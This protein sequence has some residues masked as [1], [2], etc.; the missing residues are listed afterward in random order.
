[1]IRGDR[2]VMK[3]FALF[4][5]GVCPALLL[6]GCAASLSN[7]EDFMDGGTAPRS[8]EMILAESCGGIAG[9]HDSTP[10]AAAGLDLVSPDVESRVVGVNAIGM[11]C[12]SD[13]L[14]V[15][16]N[17]DGSYLLDKVI[18]SLGICGLAMP[19]GS[20]PPLSA[21]EVETL[22]QW[23]IDLG[24]ESDGGTPDGG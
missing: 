19:T 7:P 2:R 8:A 14:V 15:A 21:D 1:M 18:P 5:F 3:R 9:C 16:G 22:R 20:V 17:P 11:G 12:E 13:I 10:Q 23:I 6:V 24:G 4:T